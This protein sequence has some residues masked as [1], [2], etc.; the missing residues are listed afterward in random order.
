MAARESAA[1]LSE[2]G[3]A[4]AEREAAACRRNSALSRVEMRQRETR[5][6]TDEINIRPRCASSARFTL[7][8]L[9]LRAVAGSGAVRC[10]D[11]CRCCC[12]CEDVRAS[13]EGLSSV[14][15]SPSV[16]AE[17]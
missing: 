12:S 10:A 3:R 17:C 13:N 1:L 9:F 15:R 6:L 14:N 8:S 11:C 4:G 5:S 2:P 7:L 16:P